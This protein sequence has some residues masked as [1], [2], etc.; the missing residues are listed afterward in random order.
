VSSAVSE[1][2]EEIHSRKWNFEFADVPVLGEQ[3]TP[4][5][6]STRLKGQERMIFMLFAATGLRAGKL[7]ALRVKHFVGNGVTVVRQ[8]VIDKCVKMEKDTKFRA[9]IAERIGL[10][11]VVPTVSRFEEKEIA[12]SC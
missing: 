4:T 9:D 5:K 3:R 10:G 12:V 7:F 2:G 11:F 1:D 6:S 8:T